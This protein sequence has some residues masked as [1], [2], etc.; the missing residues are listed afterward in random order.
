[1]KIEWDKNLATGI[2]EIDDQHK[3]LIAKINDLITSMGMGQVKGKEAVLDTFAFLEDYIYVHFKTEENYM[4]RSKYPDY[5]SHKGEHDELIMYL[6]TIKEKIMD[7]KRT[8]YLG[9]QSDM[10]HTM[11]TWLTNHIGKMDR[12]M[13]EYLLKRWQK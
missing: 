10:G 12:N 5:Q 7:R 1:M 4:N 3:K 13:G 2:E 11:Y 6:R 8:S 9:L